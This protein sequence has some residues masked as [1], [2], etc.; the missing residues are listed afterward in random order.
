MK[1]IELTISGLNSFREEQRIDFEALCADGLFGIFGPTGSG[2]STILD[3]MTLALY[4]TVERAANNT[5]GILNQLE[6]KLSVGFTFELSGE[7]TVRYRAERSYKRMKDGGLRQASCRLIKLG[8]DKAVIA[9]K[10]RDLT[11][12]IRKILGLTHDDFTR[13]VVCH[14][15]NSLNF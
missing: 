1:P 13:A 5:S 8:K 9:D 7:R 11:Q 2:K 6:Q 15:A 14:R 10:E 3:G 12:S 4:G